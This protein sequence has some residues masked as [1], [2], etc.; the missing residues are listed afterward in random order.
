M[1]YVYYLLDPVS[2][3]LLY[4]GRTNDLPARLR[5]FQAK[6][7][8]LVKSGIPQRFTDFERACQAE[9]EAIRR[10][11]PPFNKNEVSSAGRYGQL[12]SEASKKKMKTSLEGRDSGASRRGSKNSEEHRAKIKA[13]SVN[14]E[15][16]YRVKVSA[17]LKGRKMGEVTKEKLRQANLGKTISPEVRAKIKA[18]VTKTKREQHASTMLNNQ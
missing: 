16:W 2:L 9:L 3:D 14:Q 11:K 17:S 13:G 10:Y 1:F 4:I 5:S 18:S 6:H 15:G 8:L 7:G 12:H